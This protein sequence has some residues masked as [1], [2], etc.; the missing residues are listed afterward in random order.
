MEPV[1]NHYVCHNSLLTGS[2]EERKPVAVEGTL[3]VL[4]MAS[5]NVLGQRS[6]ITLGLLAPQVYGRTEY[7]LLI[8][9]GIREKAAVPGAS[10]R[11]FGRCMCILRKSANI[12]KMTL[13]WVSK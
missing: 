11:M 7:E 1:H 3:W 5:R 8:L 6:G 4:L 10:Q 12:D 13:V 9:P 2:R